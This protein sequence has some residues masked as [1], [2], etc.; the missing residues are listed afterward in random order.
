MPENGTWD[1]TRRQRLTRLDSVSLL[2]PRPTLSPIF[3]RGFTV[4]PYT[5]QFL[6]PYFALATF[7]LCLVPIQK[8]NQVMSLKPLICHFALHAAPL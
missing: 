7:Y 8:E 1:L 4:L 3:L 2:R 5:R 6:F